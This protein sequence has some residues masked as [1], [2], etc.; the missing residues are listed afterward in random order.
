M[1][2]AVPRRLAYVVNRRTVVDQATN[3]A[4]TFRK[5]LLDPGHEATGPEDIKF[6]SLVA[7]GLRGLTAFPDKP[8]YDP[9]AIS[10]LRGQFADNGEWR[11]DPARPAIVVGTVDMVGSRLLFSGYGVGF[12][13]KPLHAGFLGQD[14]LLVHDEVALG[15][16]VSEADRGD[17]RG[18]E[19]G[20]RTPGRGIAVEGHGSVGDT[21]R[22]CGNF[23]N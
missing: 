14:V 9:L 11:A 16:G 13:G 10:T 7:D 23:S 19:K 22:D 12:K 17:S 4:E 2:Q 20:T 15:A 5:R 6:R 1:P 8:D 21:T 18:A 3:E